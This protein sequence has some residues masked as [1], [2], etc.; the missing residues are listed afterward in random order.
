MQDGTIEQTET[1]TVE[2]SPIDIAAAMAKSGAKISGESFYNEEQKAPPEPPAPAKQV[3]TTATPVSKATE[4]PNVQDPKTNQSA[5][6]AAPTPN[7]EQPAVAA[8]QDW[9]EVLKQKP[10]T[11]VL[12]AMGFDDKWIGFLEEAKKG[13]DLKK[14]WDNINLDVS[15]LSAEDVMRRQ[16]RNEYPDATDEQFEDLFRAEVIEPYKLDPE[17]FQESDVKRGK[18]LLELRAGKYRKELASEQ[19]K[20]L[21][22]KPE[23]KL[24]PEV[25]Q[26]RSA[27]E[28]QRK[29]LES[30]KNTLV[31]S[32]VIKQ[33]MQ[34][35]KLTIGEGAD[36]FNYEAKNPQSIIDVLVDGSKAAAK[37]KNADGTPNILKHAL[38]GAILD[39]DITLLSSFAD[40][41]KS[42]GR[43]EAILPL[44]NPSNREPVTSKGETSFTNPAEAM[45]KTGKIVEV[46]L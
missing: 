39:D 45:A 26:F 25:E 22:S 7:Q 14:Y 23:T 35:K 34:T 24:P 31:E 20:Y 21:L 6:A 37:L 13:G 30:Y 43:K 8:P 46:Q 17:M 18:N 42:L 3:E 16:L 38:I 10:D 15:K 40:H 2:R 41:N 11:E 1:T 29:S 9:T 33:L 19:Q 28:E 44:E 32:P 4:L 5:P 27:Q 12:K 36:A